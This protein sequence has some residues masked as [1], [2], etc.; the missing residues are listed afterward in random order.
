M[1]LHAMHALHALYNFLG[2]SIDKLHAMHAFLALYNILWA[3]DHR[4]I[5]LKLLWGRKFDI[6]GAKYRKLSAK[7]RKN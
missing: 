7:L 6:V 4:R 1:G 5:S 3:S 2:A